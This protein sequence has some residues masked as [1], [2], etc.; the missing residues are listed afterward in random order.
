MRRTTLMVT[1]PVVLG[2]VLLV[3]YFLSDVNTAQVELPDTSA[4][5]VTEAP[6]GARAQTVEV[7]AKNVQAVIDTLV[8]PEQYHLSL[9]A[10]TFW[11]GGSRVELIEVWSIPGAS[12]LYRT[13]ENGRSGKHM[14]LTEETY[15]IWYDGDRTWVEMPRSDIFGAYQQAADEF[16]GI[17]NYETILALP[18]ESITEAGYDSYALGGAEVSCVYVK[19]DSGVLESTE[20]YYI[21]V[22][23]GLLVGARTYEGD[24][25]V[26][27]L[28]ANAAVDTGAVST[29]IFTLPDGTGLLE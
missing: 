5:E 22:E 3:L 28:Q 19:T 26:Y 4:E 27:E 10:E 23:T 13:D 24:T 29:E 2:L 15:Y 12:H 20:L 17:P 6:G 14:I 7:T 25:L 9:T 16:S 1:V 21:S 18:S 11:S 8:R